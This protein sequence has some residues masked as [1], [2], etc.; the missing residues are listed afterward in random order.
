ML[1]SYHSIRKK[2]NHI[3]RS[4]SCRYFSK[5]PEPLPV[6]RSLSRTFLPSPHKLLPTE[7]LP[8]TIL[9]ANRGEIA[10]RVF[11]TAE[12][13]GL[14]TVA[15]YTNADISSTHIRNADV[16]RE[17]PNYIDTEA[18]IK[19][20]LEENVDCVHP[21]YGF[22]SENPSFPQLCSDN[23]IT[24][25][26][27]TG[28]TMEQFGLKDRA[29]ET[30]SL[31][32]VA[33]VPG[34]GVVKDVESAVTEAEKIGYPLM[35]KAVSGGG[36]IGMIKCNSEEDLRSRFEPTVRQALQ[37]F[38]NGD[39]YLEKFVQKPRHIEVQV[40]GDGKGKAVHLGE[41]ECSI[42][43]R[44]QKIIEEAPSPFVSEFKDL[45]EKLTGAAVQ[46]AESVNYNSA[47]TVEFLVDGETG[48]FY[49]LEMNT[50]LQVEHPITEAIT[51]VDIV[52]W[53]IRQA[54][55]E[56]SAKPRLYDFEPQLVGH[57]IEA[58][59][60][61]EDALRDFAPSPGLL[62]EVKWPSQDYARIDTWIEAGTVVTPNFDPMIAKLIVHGKNRGDAIMMFRSALQS[63]R[64]SG[65]TTNLKYLQYIAGRNFFSTGNYDT[66]TISKLPSALHGGFKPEGI[67]IVSPG[68]FT[69]IQDYP[70]RTA[71]QAGSDT[72]RV[73]IPPSGGMDFVALR[74][75]NRLVNNVET[76]ATLEITTKGPTIN[77]NEDTV[78]ALCGA[79]FEAYLDGIPVPMWESVYAP[80]GSCLEIGKV[81]DG[82]VGCRA[83]LAFSGGLDVPLYMGSRSTL[84]LGS[85]GGHQGRTLTSRDNIPLSRVPLPAARIRAPSSLI[86]EYSISRS[87]TLHKNSDGS[88]SWDIN[89]LPGPQ[90]HPDFLTETGIET[91]YNSE[92]KV[93]YNSNRLGVRFIGP[94]LEWKREDGG[95]G[96]SH[97][98]NVLDNMYAIG[99]INVSGDMPIAITNDGPSLGGFACVATVP[100]AELWKIGQVKPGDTVQF[101][102]T[103]LPEA[104]KKKRMLEKSIGAIGLPQGAEP[105]GLKLSQPV[106]TS[107][108][109]KYSAILME[110]PAN[111]AT[112]SPEVRCRL[113]GDCYVLYEYGP[114]YL[115]EIDLNHRFRVHAFEQK[116]HELTA[117]G[118]IHP[119]AIIE[120]SPGIRSLQ[121]N[122]D[123]AYISLPNLLHVLEETEL[124]LPS[125]ETLTL[126][127][128]IVN[129]PIALD[130]RWSKDALEKYAKS[131]RADAPYLPNNLEFLARSNGLLGGVEE[132]KQ[133]ILDASYMVLGLGDVYLGCP[134]A[135]PIDPRHRLQCPK[136]NPARTYTP[137]G[138]VGIGGQFMCL[139]PTASPGGYQLVGRSLPIWNTYAINESFA[140]A[141]PWLLRMFDQVRFYEVS[142][143]ELESMIEPFRNGVIDIDIE[144]KDFSLSEYNDFIKKPDVIAETEVFLE[145]Q[146]IATDIEL[147]KEKM[148]WQKEKLQPKEE[149]STSSNVEESTLQL[150][151]HEGYDVVSADFTANVW[152][153]NFESGSHVEKGDTV[154]VLECMKMEHEIVANASGILTDILVKTGEIAN[155]GRPLFIIEEN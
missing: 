63:T 12:K 1:F 65:T 104:L 92:W 48:D 8:K 148:Y 79:K 123:D 6:V 10:N 34:S 72:W 3:V 61:C 15:V 131:V 119:S 14:R 25:L 38:A 2:S 153:V 73:G 74:A 94:R 130:D 21:G 151:D 113:Q 23:G 124:S 136:F 141:R 26:G 28:H 140:S 118:E 31:A 100:K 5:E 58:R 143:D 33:V 42:Q 32:G 22:V 110:L 154:L 85:L 18:L 96:G 115:S 4:L 97:P 105:A 155:Q 71:T 89:T 109:S 52:E 102:S 84:T 68:I 116:L 9:V 98:S 112:N 24:F 57:A 137:E 120:T 76:S 59:I 111:S 114:S 46:L 67:T 86:D 62:T 13:L 64:L 70:G 82:S 126:P 43:R 144:E 36:G 60:Y 101:S 56:E 44:H 121:I 147:E 90:E 108:A 146:K 50:R 142:D 138:A 20:C 40:F 47:G 55:T 19:V 87:S 80:S 133:I 77:I 91:F 107:V 122:Y 127:S 78:M 51:Q 30:A 129:I 54:A 7:G 132:A 103:T 128:R 139:Y 49:F 150:I 17:I 11:Q 152:A 125:M 39:M 88:T 35:L 93:H 37:F 53:M 83:Y 117:T 66:G 16:A 27:P 145:R 135:M 134:A 81:S 69:S 95:A 149:T 41:R 45:R 75:A 29:R 106:Q 99:A